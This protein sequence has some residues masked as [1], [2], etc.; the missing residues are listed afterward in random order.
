MNER[1]TQSET[2]LLKRGYL[3]KNVRF[4]IERVNLTSREDLFKESEKKVD[5]SAI[6]VLTFH[7]AMNCVHRIPR[8][9]HC[10]VLKSNRLS[11]ILPPPPRVVICNAKSLKDR[12]VRSKLKPKSDVTTGNFDCG[13]KRCEICKILVPGNEFKSLVTKKSYKMSFLFACLVQYVD[14]S[15]RI[16]G[17]PGLEKGLISTS[18]T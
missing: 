10:H 15:I 18:R 9:A 14:V 11:R 16:P 12:L 4:E 17:L 1:L 13:S 5:E 3:H 7:P 6:L 8:E 2:W